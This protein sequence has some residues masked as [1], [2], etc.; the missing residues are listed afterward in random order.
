MSRRGLPLAFV[1]ILLAT[2]GCLTSARPATLR[3]ADGVSVAP[4]HATVVGTVLS[5]TG[6]PLSQAV[7]RLD[8]VGLEMT[9]D[10]NGRFRF[11]DMPPGHYELIASHVGYAAY[12]HGLDLKADTV[13]RVTVTLPGLDL[14]G[15]A[16]TIRSSD[17][18]GVVQCS[19]N[20]YYPTNACSAPL[21]PDEDHFT[22]DLEPTMVPRQVLV[23]LVWT[24]TTPV[25]GQALELDVCV[26]PATGS[27]MNCRDATLSSQWHKDASGPSP[28]RLS[29]LGSDLARDVRT[30]AVWV[31][32]GYLSPY[33]ALT[34]SFT[35]YV[36][37]CYLTTCPQG[38][39]AVP[40]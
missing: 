1:A 35:A 34:Q 36:T 13:N 10:T 18:R 21:G 12:R 9:T 30:Y 6:L 24:P 26:P 16:A 4:G 39:T 22:V 27:A 19:Y 33:P 5:P 31:G 25:T 40:A 38:Y 2:A 20:A 11:D 32:D 23:E 17:F 37:A 29:L 7:A 28:L 8:P 15:G 14:V 3:D